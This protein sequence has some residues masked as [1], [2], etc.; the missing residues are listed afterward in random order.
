MEKAKLM[1]FFRSND[2]ADLDLFTSFVDNLPLGDLCR[3][4]ILTL[5]ESLFGNLNETSLEF[6]YV[7]AGRFIYSL[8][9]HSNKPN[10]QIKCH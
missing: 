2:K 6:H 10:L 9:E 4:G 5:Y 7:E 1:P 8:L 3:K